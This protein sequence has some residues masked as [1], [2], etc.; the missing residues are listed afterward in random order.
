MHFNLHTHET[1]VLVAGILGLLEQEFMRIVLD[2][3]PSQVL[4]GIFGS[5]VL[6]SIGVGVVRA[7]RNGKNGVKE[8][9]E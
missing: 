5:M 9:E 3:P 4:S 8:K 6:A 2:V 7:S 1:L